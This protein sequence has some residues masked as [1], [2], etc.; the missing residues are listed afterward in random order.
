MVIINQHRKE[1]NINNPKKVPPFK[2]LPMNVYLYDCTD[3][4]MYIL[5]SIYIHTHADINVLIYTHINIFV[6]IYV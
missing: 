4:F 3:A 5:I 6:L 1:G 2:N